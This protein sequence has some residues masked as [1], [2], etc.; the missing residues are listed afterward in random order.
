MR[1]KTI[2]CTKPFAWIC[3]FVINHS[4]FS[5]YILCSETFLHLRARLQCLFA[6]FWQCHPICVHRLHT[7]VTNSETWSLKDSWYQPGRKNDIK[8]FDVFKWWQ[9]NVH[10]YVRVL[11]PVCFHTNARP[12]DDARLYLSLSI[13]ASVWWVVEYFISA[14]GAGFSWTGVVLVPTP[15]GLRLQAW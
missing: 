4:R 15:G 9:T 5:I 2:G 1:H 3:C 13:L 7:H 12:W 14:G 11:V 6:L 10:V 8:G